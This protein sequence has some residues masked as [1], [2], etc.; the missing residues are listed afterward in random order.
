MAWYIEEQE[1][2]YLDYNATTPLEREV[3]NA[4]AE[5]MKYWANPSSNSP[6]GVKAK[7][8]I[9]AARDDV[10]KMMHVNSK[11]VFFTSGGTE[12][13]YW[14]IHSAIEHF[15]AIYGRE[16]KPHIV[17]SSIEHPSILEPLH[18]LSQKGELEHTEIGVDPSTGLVKLDDLEAAL[19]ERTVLVS[20]MLANNE[21]GVIQPL[22]QIADIARRAG[23][24]Y[25]S[26]VLVHTDAAQAVGKM[27]VDPDVLKTDFVTVVGHK[28]YGPRIGA[29]VIRSEKTVPL[30]SLFRGGSQEHEKRAGTENTPMIAGL[31]AACR[32]VI[33]RLPDF[34]EHMR[35]VRDYFEEQLKNALGDAVVI[36]FATSQRIPNTS[37]VSFVKYPGNAS[38]LLSKC[39][40]FFA[41]TGAACHAGTNRISAVLSACGILDK[42]AFRTVRF[43]FGRD[44]SRAQVDR[45]VNELKSIAFF[46][47]YGSSLLSAINKGP[48][49]GF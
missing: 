40:S 3:E 31:G 38:D 26:R 48:L 22:S 9:E 5:S 14:V 21:T 15:K 10:A 17:T 24:R 4:I 33:E 18:W 28:F 16:G 43:S 42:V 46:G 7:E 27:D 11:E 39:K 35:D 8:V 19:C 44:S 45:V 49:P 23:E 29:L 41:S 25:D 2:I 47:K 6:L 30:Q 12:T 32:I 1:R 37:S 20:V 13:N 36:H 34:V